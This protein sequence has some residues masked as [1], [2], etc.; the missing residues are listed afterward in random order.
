MSFVIKI[1]GLTDSGKTTVSKKLLF[2]LKQNDINVIHFDGDILRN[3]F[4]QNDK[5]S[6]TKKDRIN[7]GK[8]YANLCFFMN[9]QNI[10]VIISTIGLYDEIGDYSRSIIKNYYEIFLDVPLNIL[11]KRDT[12][13]I[14]KKFSEG[15][16]KNVY[17]LD[18]HYDKP[19]NADL[20]LDNYSVTPD[21]NA[22]VIFEFLE[23]RLFINA[24]Q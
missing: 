17:G 24:K 11:Q 23:N 19:A 10:N 1:S 4:N 3:I 18:L 21:D 13:N 8:Q 16:L 7:L 14:Y 20:I 6:Y 22:K 12:K 9:Q 2:I 5:K 15:K